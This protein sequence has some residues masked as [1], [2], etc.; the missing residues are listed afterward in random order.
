MAAKQLVISLVVILLIG[1]ALVPVA[2]QE[3]DQRYQWAAYPFAVTLPDGWTAAST[4][5]RLVL[6]L[7]DDV[8]AALSGETPAGIVVDVRVIDLPDVSQRFESPLAIYNTGGQRPA[9]ESWELDDG[10]MLDV[11]RIP[12]LNDREGM[13]VEIADTY[14]ITVSYLIGDW[15]QDTTQRIITDLFL[16]IDAEPAQRT[17]SERLT[18]T[19]TWRDLSFRLPA[20]W[21]LTSFGNPTELEA[22]TRIGAINFSTRFAPRELIILM[23]D[24]NP[25][26]TMITPGSINA[27]TVGWFSSE[28]YPLNMPYSVDVPGFTALRSDF[29][30]GDDAGAVLLLETPES[31]YFIVG[32]ANIDMWQTS[33]QELF[34]AILATLAHVESD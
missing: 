30:I 31:A 22:T 11:L 19:I 34:E 8:A 10:N 33:E 26:R 4:Q 23:R 9:I 5:D 1:T 3:D 29:E 2:A 16:S 20:D 27:L 15:Q 7:P 18:E 24:L 17:A 13:L 12:S 32:I 6:G 21:E 25:L 14:L 28:D